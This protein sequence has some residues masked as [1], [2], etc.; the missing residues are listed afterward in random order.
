MRWQVPTC[1]VRCGTDF[2]GAIRPW[3]EE[4]TMDPGGHAASGPTSPQSGATPP[5][6]LANHQR[7]IVRLVHE[8]AAQMGADVELLGEGWII[9]CTHRASGRSAHIYGYGF[10]LNPAGVHAI[11]CDKAATSE[12]LSR[13][14]VACVPHMLLLH[15]KMARFVAHD[16]T[17]RQAL[18]A[19]ERWDKDVV[20]KENA[21]TG[22]R[23]VLRARTLVELEHAVYSLF[24]SRDAI[25]IS[26]YRAAR[27]EHRFVL[28]DGRVLLAY[29]KVRRAVVGDGV[30]TT[31]ALL[32]REVEGAREAGAGRG[33]RA[34]LRGMLEEMDPAQRRSLA[35]VPAVGEQRLLNWRH[36]LGQG[37][38]VALLSAEA[39]ATP[40][41]ARRAALAQRAAGVMGLRFGSVDVITRA[42]GTDGGP[43]GGPDIGPDEVLEVN[44]GVMME[45]LTRTL[46]QGEELARMVYGKALRA[47]LGG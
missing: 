2:I 3:R 36:N 11:A 30:S 19:W 47:M 1:S 43:G 20:V 39:L 26:P 25:A 45:F 28:L 13:H 7:A 4:W 16:G 46:P 34:G 27:H 9:R 22:G 44:A 21:G 6:G 37:A 15:P 5:D 8:L 31:L 40:E 42:D 14:G 10:D 29:E 12:L 35:D 23:D 41:H 17:W 33:E 38:S 18:A 24:A 32:A